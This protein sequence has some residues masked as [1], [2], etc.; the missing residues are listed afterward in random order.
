MVVHVGDSFKDIAKTWSHL[1]S[2][3]NICGYN[4]IREH[5]ACI[6]SEIKGSLM[7]LICN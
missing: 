7:S 5:I 3:T 4:L 2:D 1:V 6:Y